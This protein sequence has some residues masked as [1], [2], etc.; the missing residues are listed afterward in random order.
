MHWWLLRYNFSDSVNLPLEIIAYW[1][2]GLSS[3]TAQER[4]R[5]RATYH[6]ADEKLL[7]QPAELA[8]VGPVVGVN[9]VLVASGH[10]IWP[11]EEAKGRMWRVIGWGGKKGNAGRRG[12]QHNQRGGVGDKTGDRLGSKGNLSVPTSDS[13]R[14]WLSFLSK[15]CLLPAFIM[16]GGSR[17]RLRLGPVWQGLG[18]KL[19]KERFPAAL[20]SD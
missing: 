15:N 7:L 12:R 18:D 13:F 5:W 8:V 10:W 17:E 3:L 14:L 4:G 16:K 1:Q 9:G 20:Q 11:R 2:I 19:C 6:Y